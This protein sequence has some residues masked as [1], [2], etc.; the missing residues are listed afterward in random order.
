MVVLVAT[1]VGLPTLVP[2][3]QATPVSHASALPRRVPGA[4]VDRPPQS[5]DEIRWADLPT[6]EEPLSGTPPGSSLRFERFS[7]QHGLSQSSILCMLQDSAGFMWFGTE[8]GLNKFDGY[9]FT[10]LRHDPENPNSLSHN[11]VFSIDEDRSDALW[12]RTGGGGIDRLDRING[13]ITRYHHD[14]D[15]P[16]SLSS[17]EATTVH[18][19]RSGTVW[20]GTNGGGLNRFDDTSGSF[21]R[22]RHDPDVPHS[23]SHDVVTAIHEDRSGEL[24][25]GT[26]AGGLNRL[27]PVTGESVRYQNDPDD[28]STL[29][30]DRIT[31]IHEDRSG[32]LWIGTYEGGLVRFDR[33]T[34]QFRRW[35]SDPDDPNTLSND[36]VAL[37]AEDRS[38]SLWIRTGGAGLDRLSP[39]GDSVVRYRHDPDAAGSL[40][41]DSV[42]TLHEDK[43]GV[44]WIG[45]YGGGL[46]SFDPDSG[47]FI[48]HQYDPRDPHSLSNDIVIAIYEDRLGALWI[49][50]FGGGVNRYDRSAQPY[51]LYRHDPDDPNSLSHNMVLS[52]DEDESGVLWIGTGGGGICA[53]DPGSREFTRYQTDPENPHSL[54]DGVVWSVHL[55]VSGILWAGT[56]GGLDRLDSTTGEFTHFRSDA[57]DPASLSHNTVGT[58]AEDGSGRLWVGTVQGLNRFDRET[59]AFT[60]YVNEPDDPHSL[61]ANVIWCLYVD[62]SGVLWVGTRGGGLDRFVPETEQF[63]H[64]RNDPDDPNS[65]SDDR[66]IS[67]YED[68]TGVFWIGTAGGGLNRMDPATGDFTRYREKDGLPNDVVYGILED[69]RGNLWLSTNKGIARFDPRKAAFKSYDVSD[70]LQSNEFNIGAY[71]STGDGQML[72]GGINGFNAFRPSEVKDNSR[73]PPIV[74][75]TLTQ[76]GEPLDPHTPVESTEEVKL[77][78]P[79]NYFEFGYAALS[80]VQP[81]KNQYAYMLEGLEKDWIQ[82]GSRR[83]G[84]YTNLPGRTYTL[85]VKGSNNDGV[86]NEAGLSL[87]VTVVPPFWA[88]WWFRGAVVLLV[89]GVVVGGYR[90]RLSSIRARSRELESEVEERTY[91]IERRRQELEALYRADAELLR[92]LRLDEVLQAL[93]DIAV[94]IL[95]ADK[96]SVLVWDEE[97]ARLVMKAARGFGAHAMA[98][99]SS[100]S[101][102]EGIVGR[103][104]TTGEPAVVEDALVDPRR[105]SE[106]P[107]AVQA[108]DAEGIRS[109]MHLPIRIEGEVFGVFNVSFTEPR[110]FGEDEQRLFTGLAQRAALAIENAQLYE[111]SRELAAIEE[112]SRLARD[113]HDAVTQTLFSAS[114]IAETLPPLY[115]SDREEGEQLLQELRRLSRGA[116]AEMRTLLMELRPAALVETSL[117]DLLRQLGEAAI[118]RTGI[119]IHVSVDGPCVLP[120][121]VHVALYRIAQEALNNVVKHAK[122]SEVTVGLRCGRPSG[123]STTSSHGADN[124]HEVELSV[125]DDGCGFDAAH[126]PLDRL[127]L[128]I[129]RERAQAIGADLT[130]NSELGRGTQVVVAWRGEAT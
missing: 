11:M 118:G 38:N 26:R 129:I 4:Q 6:D 102:S 124:G 113:L 101:G 83:F 14:P 39:N 23:L 120:T 127:G 107:E 92:H 96:S 67:V 97:R 40:S 8:D 53:F 114:L 81:E 55:D 24:W 30:N 27:D 16:G 73:V 48:R 100:F 72:F 44:L 54:T 98:H 119:P 64:Y 106:R 78:W 99:L 62:R 89:A 10:V 31:L 125:T 46:N 71:F 85:R 59:E 19:G 65:L 126:I 111:Q 58:I 60:R 1:L 22:Y 20:I 112:R 130:I 80:Y 57:D 122:A 52:F 104:A 35:Q 37:V 47:R 128:G 108:L 42:T 93:A 109:F 45:T 82:V 51:V 95:R 41:N 21:V 116:M 66:V 69:D 15:D 9:D 90:V 49:G 76:A 110:A 77:R 115:Q 121:E 7:I 94:D 32:N 86:W 33:E 56:G 91:E 3:W 50:T 29:S 84:R 5:F 13:D 117:G 28:P 70:G 68:R 79:A 25:V 74:L 103:V 75:T 87:K 36:T 2:S 123:A 18:V 34:Q 63:V 17:D 12:V 43:T 88:T 105:E 61:S